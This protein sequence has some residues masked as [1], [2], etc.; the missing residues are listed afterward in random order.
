MRELRIENYKFTRSSPEKSAGFTLTV[1]SIDLRGGTVVNV[2]GPSGSGKSTLFNLLSGVISDKIGVLVGETFK[3]IAYL[4]HEPS[5]MAWRTVEENFLVERKLRRTAAPIGRFKELL[6]ACKLRDDVLFA[7]AKTLSFGMRQ[8][9]ELARALAFN[10]ELL[11]LDEG[12]SGLDSETK[13]A[14]FS[15]ILAEVRQR[16]MCVLATSHYL[17]DVLAFSDVIHLLKDG[18]LEVAGSIGLPIESRLSMD[19]SQLHAQDEIAQILKR[20]S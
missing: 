14:A 16:K 4:M 8:R 13:K 9:V 17:P 20:L 19:Q 3:T 18:S 6:R 1:P 2:V 7:P 11:I 5:L 12:L 15:L 10:P